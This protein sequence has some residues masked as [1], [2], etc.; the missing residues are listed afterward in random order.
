MGKDLLVS[1]IL[2]TK[3]EGANVARFLNSIKNQRSVKPEIIVV[4]NNSC[5]DTKDIASKFTDKVY[6][7][8]PERSVQRNFGAEKSSGKYLLF[9]DADMELSPGVIQDCVDTTQKLNVKILTIPERTVGE[10]FIPQIR[11]FEREMYLEEPDYEVPRFYERE[12]FFKFGGYDKNLTGPEDYDLPY[13][14][15][16]EYKVGRSNDFILHHEEN[17]TLKKLLSKKYY[18]AKRGASYASKHPKLV[19]VQ[20]TILFRRVYL[21]NWRKFVH[22]PLLGISFLWVRLLET[23]WAVAGFISAVGVLDF[24]KTLFKLFKK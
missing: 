12:L 9:L 23:V 13:R 22:H 21:R 20:G 18:Y 19:W 15:S 4:D 14:I 17:L 16:R 7:H 10:G 5:D 2:T 6:N 1:V 24:L 8:G 11:K 3:N